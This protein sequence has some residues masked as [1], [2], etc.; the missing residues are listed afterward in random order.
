MR[1]VIIDKIENIEIDLDNP[2]IDN[3]HALDYLKEGIFFLAKQVKATEDLF[4]GPKIRPVQEYEKD[5]FP[6]QEFI[7]EQEVLG[8]DFTGKYSFITCIF[9]WFAISVVNYARVIALIDYLQRNN[10]RLE[11]IIEK[12][13]K[14][15]ISN[16]CK[17]YVKKVVPEIEIFR[18]KIAAHFSATDPYNVDNFVDLELSLMSTLTTY[19]GNFEINGIAFNRNGTQNNQLPIWSVTQE[20]EKLKTRFW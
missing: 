7:T 14:E 18:N 19:E 4:L 1:K 12:D 17:E 15:K 5:I 13:D 20:F 10:L 2:P 3:I 8:M 6:G 11:N 9:H 16:Y